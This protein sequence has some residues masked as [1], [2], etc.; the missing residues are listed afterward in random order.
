[1]PDTA[2]GGYSNFNRYFFAQVGKEAV[3]VTSAST[4]AP[5]RRTT[6]STTCAG[7]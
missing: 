2:F 5:A 1:L 7:R 6:S 3:I 4:G